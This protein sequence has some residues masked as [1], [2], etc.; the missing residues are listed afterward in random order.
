MFSIREIIELA[1]QIEK[2][3]EMIYRNALQSASNKRVYRL[4]QRFAHEEAQHVEWFTKLKEKVQSSAVD[5]QLEEMGK[6]I[7]L[8]VLGNQAFSLKDVDLSG[9]NETND[10]LKSA[11]EF[12][13]DT[14]VFY[15][16]ICSFIEDQETLSQL[17]NVIEEENQHVRLFQKFL[18]T[19][20]FELETI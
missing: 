3:G 6:T 18:D 17:E 9:I 20:D 19:G 2:N 16:M 8:G 12:E 1:I 14:I 5:P 7:L 4:I 13:Q 11:I 15:E 10:L